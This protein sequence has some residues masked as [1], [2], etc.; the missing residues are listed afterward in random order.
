MLDRFHPAVATWFAE[1]FGAPTEAQIRGWASIHDG[2]D[3]LIMAPTGS[4]K[5][6]AA[7]LAAIDALVREGSTLPATTRVLYVSPLKALAND[8]QKNL[9]APLA[10]LRQRDASLPEVRVLV[11]SGDTPQ[12]ERAEM[13]RRA[14]HVLVTTPES[15]YILLTSAGGRKLLGDV[16]TVIVDEIHAVLGDKRGAHLALSLERLSA[17]VERAGGREPQR[18]GLSATQK[19][20]SAVADYLGG[21]GRSVHVVDQGT[22]RALDLALELP[23]TPLEPVCSHETWGEVYKRVSEL[24]LAHRTTLVFVQTRKLAERVAAQLATLLGTAKVTCH[25]SSLAKERRLAA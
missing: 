17:L 20:L 7:F 21:V 14:P 18:I 24:V 16:R 1:R 15:L 25:H 8:V 9:L 23:P 12:S 5:T 22:F 4:G 19:P 6:L 2:A 3:T 10:E 13:T 11:R